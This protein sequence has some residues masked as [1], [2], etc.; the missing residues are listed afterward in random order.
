MSKRFIK[1]I[2]NFFVANFLLAILIHLRYCYMMSITKY[3]VTCGV[4]K[5]ENSFPK[6]RNVCRACKTQSKELSA[7]ANYE[8]YLTQ[9]F[10]NS[11]SKAASGQRDHIRDFSITKEDVLDL[12]AQQNGRCAIS[13]VILTHH[14]DGTGAK[15]FNASLDRIYNNKGYTKNNVH[16]VCYR[17]NLLKH[18]LPNDMFY[19]WI[20]TICQHSC[21]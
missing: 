18:T 15:D 19:W 14:K 9:L 20:K 21:D 1:Q 10:I 8:T 5:P 13:G 16:L 17:V 7:S 3:C 6:D 2:S 11:R 12:W 4:E